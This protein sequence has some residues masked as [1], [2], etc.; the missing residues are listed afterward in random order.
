MRD[1]QS[2]PGGVAQVRPAVRDV[3]ARRFARVQPVARK[4]Q[5]G[6]RAHVKPDGLAVE[7]ASRL[8]V[9]AEHEYVLHLHYSSVGLGHAAA[10][11][12]SR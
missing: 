10:L 8:D 1:R 6:T 12:R 9:V 7:I 11:P 2:Q 5:V 3:Q 4:L